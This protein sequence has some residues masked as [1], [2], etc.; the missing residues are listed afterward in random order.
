[1]HEE[2]T[3]QVICVDLD[4]TLCNGEAWTEEDCLLATPRTDI[5]EKVNALY[6]RNFI[7]LYTARRDFLIPASLEWLRKN[8]V[9]YHAWSNIKI[10]AT[11]YIDD[12][13][14]SPES[15]L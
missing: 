9:R 1:M 8:N 14:F 11:K 4:G 12:K 2:I 10:P 5:I 3:K 13:F 7:V 15:L 6:Q